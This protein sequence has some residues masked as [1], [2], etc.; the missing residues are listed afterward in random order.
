M[1]DD[2]ERLDGR[3][4]AMTADEKAKLDD[5][6]GFFMRPRAP[7]RPSRAQEIDEVLSA[8]AAG[9]IGIR[10]GLWLAGT[11]VAVSA[12]W[13]AVRGAMWP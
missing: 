7:G 11:I 2:L 5:L 9:R 6:H 1:L 13:T 4:K 8:V 3:R 10:L 12:A